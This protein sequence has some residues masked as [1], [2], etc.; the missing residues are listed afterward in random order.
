MLPGVMTSIWHGMLYG[1]VKRAW[2]GICYGLEGMAWYM[3]WLVGIAW[4]MYWHG[5]VW[6]SIYNCLVG[7]GMVY[8]MACQA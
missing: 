8:G 7:Y 4:Y 2:H 6:H 5:E 3:V 1:M